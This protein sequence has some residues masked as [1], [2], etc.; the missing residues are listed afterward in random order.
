MCDF[1]G[2]L[3]GNSLWSI[4]TLASEGLLF[5]THY[6]YSVAMSPAEGGGIYMKKP[7]LMVTVIFSPYDLVN[8]RLII[9]PFLNQASGV[10]V[11]S[12]PRFRQE[13]IHSSRLSDCFRSIRCRGTND[14]ISSPDMTTYVIIPL[15]NPSAP[16]AIICVPATW[17]TC[18]LKVTS[19]SIFRSL[20]TNWNNFLDLRSASI[21][22]ALI[23]RVFI[24]ENK[25]LHCLT[26]HFSQ[27]LPCSNTRD[28]RS[29]LESLPVKSMGSL[30]KSVSSWF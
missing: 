16:C 3:Y 15:E 10:M 29:F 4:I 11:T 30:D 22:G 7:C 27:H 5:I 9:W 23:G 18:I 17:M 1:F 2:H 24:E 20:E 28:G 6:N 19:I 12:L 25:N 21:V 8:C 26:N 14:S 13:F